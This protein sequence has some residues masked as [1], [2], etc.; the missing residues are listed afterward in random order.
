MVFRGDW[1]GG[2]GIRYPLEDFVLPPLE[3]FKLNFSCV[4]YVQWN[5]C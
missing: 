5:L 1:G 3:H 4:D 2:G